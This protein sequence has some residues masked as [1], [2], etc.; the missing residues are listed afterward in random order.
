M[1]IFRTIASRSFCRPSPAT[2]DGRK[3]SS[4]PRT[5]QLGIRARGVRIVTATNSLNPDAKS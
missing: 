1:A 3:S 2:A 5:M 4:L